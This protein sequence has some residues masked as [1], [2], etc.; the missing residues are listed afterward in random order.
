MGWK[1]PTT[2]SDRWGSEVTTMYN[3]GATLSVVLREVQFSGKDFDMLKPD[4]QTPNALLD[5]FTLNFGTLCGCTFD[6]EIETPVLARD[7]EQ[8]GILA[9]HLELGQPTHSRGIGRELLRLSLRVDGNAYRSEG[10]TGWFEDELLSLQRALPGGMA[11]K[12]CFTCAYSDYSPYGHGLFGG[13]AC[14]RSFK[15]EYSRV[16]SKDDLF[17]LLDKADR[18]QETYL[19]ADFNFR[20]PHTGY[21]G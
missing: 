18:V 16:Q 3:D 7:K 20:K 5:K 10:T 17:P 21:R 1:Y 2:F 8:R 9:A 13:M 6:I 4:P 15:A 19:C 14:F 12:T 11:L